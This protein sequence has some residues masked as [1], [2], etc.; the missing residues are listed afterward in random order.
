[1]TELIDK[2]IY[3]TGDI[4]YILKTKT[5]FVRNTLH[6]L[7]SWSE[8]EIPVETIN[9]RKV[10][11]YRQ[12]VFVD[13]LLF[14]RSKELHWSKARTVILQ[15]QKDNGFFINRKWH[16]ATDGVDVFAK[17]EDF[18]QSDTLA[19][20]HTSQLTMRKVIEPLIEWRIFETLIE[21]RE[22]S[23]KSEI[24]EWKPDP[25]FPDIRVHP[26]IGFGKPHLEGRM[27]KSETLFD[28]YE[29][30]NDLDRLAWEFE[31][32]K[33]QVS[34]AIRFEQSRRNSEDEM[35]H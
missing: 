3:S 11:S 24:A 8:N 14:L 5:A 26:A 18:P 30:E 31:L 4:A 13:I 2:P 7:E 35:V 16:L 12:C 32:E 1:M 25:D 19:S 28:M 34:E 17:H 10:A 29:D 33:D 23:E 27:I 20:V 22:F 9:D 15:L 21:R 6:N